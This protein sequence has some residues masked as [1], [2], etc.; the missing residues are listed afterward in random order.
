VQG[1]RQKING[2]RL[3]VVGRRQNW[4]VFSYSP[5]PS[6]YSLQPHLLAKEKPVFNTGFPLLLKYILM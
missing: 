3:K 2:G 1:G 4:K 5:Q 6:A